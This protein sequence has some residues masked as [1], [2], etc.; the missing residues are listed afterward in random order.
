MSDLSVL[1]LKKQICLLQQARGNGTSLIS[2]YMSAG[3]QVSEY[4]KLLTQELGTA[5]CIKSR[6]VRLAV[7]EAIRSLQHRLRLLGHKAPANGLA[8]FCGVVESGSKQPKKVLQAVEPI[9]PL[10]QWRYLCDST[11]HVEMLKEQ[12]EGGTTYG[13]VIVDGNGTTCG[14]LSGSRRR[15]LCHVSVNLPKKH[16]KGG[17]SAGRFFRKC[18]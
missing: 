12:L 17:Q 3:S 16:N 7:L 18:V 9:R 1:R 5:K 14:T 13:F 8:L 4:N 15:T 2:L 6:V 11:F 10:R